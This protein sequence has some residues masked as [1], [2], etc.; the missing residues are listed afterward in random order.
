MFSDKNA[1]IM[2]L[3]SWGLFL[4]FLMFVHLTE[5]IWEQAFIPVRKRMYVG[6]I[7]P[8]AGMDLIFGTRYSA[9]CDTHVEFTNK[10]EGNKY[11]YIIHQKRILRKKKVNAFCADLQHACTETYVRT[12]ECAHACS[13]LLAD[14]SQTKWDLNSLPYIPSIHTQRP[15]LFSLKGPSLFYVYRY[16]TYL[17][18]HMTYR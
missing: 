4:F 5:N 16:I 11:D 14:Y 6:F 3:R 1:I 15:N 2:T 13:Y 10:I 17:L 9:T 12:R 7:D 18:N 8:L